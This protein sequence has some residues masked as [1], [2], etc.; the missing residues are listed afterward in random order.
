M[1]FDSGDMSM[2]SYGFK[3]TGRDIPPALA[4]GAA[5]GVAA[6]GCIIAGI[7]KK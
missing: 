2:K 1:V 7:T 5:V 3:A 4:A 6:V